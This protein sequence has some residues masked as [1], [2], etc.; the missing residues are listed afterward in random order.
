MR[1]APLLAILT[2]LT[3]AAAAHAAGLR[4]GGAL[5]SKGD[6]INSVLEACGEPT[7]EAALVNDYGNEIGTVLYFDPGHGRDERRVE[8][9]GGRVSL[10]ERMR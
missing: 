2:T 8:F 5:V 10:I 4:C 9:R 1:S 3:L 6:S 7:R